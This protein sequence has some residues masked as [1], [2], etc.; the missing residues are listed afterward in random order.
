[1]S[2]IV[3]AAAIGA[4]ASLASSTVSAIGG[5]KA[6]KRALD[7]NKKLMALQNQY[8]IENWN[9]ENEYNDPRNV[10]DR[11][12][13][14]G[15]N[16]YSVIDNAGVGVA[17]S[18]DNPNSAYSPS[19]SDFNYEAMF[20]DRLSGASNDFVNNLNTEQKTA[21]D[22]FNQDFEK[23]MNEL[24]LDLKK[25]DISY[26]KYNSDVK[27]MERNYQM[28]TFSDRLLTT[29][30]ERDWRDRFLKNET[31]KL[32]QEGSA[33][34][35]VLGLTMT[36]NRGWTDDDQ[37]PT[38]FGAW[39]YKDEKSPDYYRKATNNYY[40]FLYRGSK[41]KN[42][43]IYNA[44]LNQYKNAYTQSILEGI[45]ATTAKS[46]N[47]NINLA[48]LAESAN[49]LA[50]T[51]FDHALRNGFKNVDWNMLLYYGLK[52]ISNL[53]NNGVNTWLDTKIHSIYNQQTIPI[54]KI[55]F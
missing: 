19:A 55:G 23:A 5:R 45:E 51:N 20:A 44:F 34:E 40:N 41:D 11:Y 53:G 8:N 42:N 33:L 21:H 7:A 29:F 50:E 35:D 38:N 15:L 12:R 37:N 9:R 3:G 1:M 6:T 10:M 47:K 32:I 14:A 27:L 24:N 30:L 39:A 13:K 18:L 16:P 28:F 2:A 4:L 54:R 43:P 52:S 22:K 26:A 49:R 36:E 25:H 17:G 48:K 31:A 46:I